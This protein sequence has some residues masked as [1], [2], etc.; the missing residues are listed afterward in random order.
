MDEKTICGIKTANAKKMMSKNSRACPTLLPMC[1]IQ[2]WT[3]SENQKPAPP[4]QEKTSPAP[5]R[6]PAKQK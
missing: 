2:C 6:A 3:T 4:R 1:G 5:P